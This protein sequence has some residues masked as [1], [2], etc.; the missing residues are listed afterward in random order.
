MKVSLSAMEVIALR[1]RGHR[2]KSWKLWEVIVSKLTQDVLL[3]YRIYLR[4]HFLPK[5]KITKNQKK[6]PN[7]ELK[8]KIPKPYLLQ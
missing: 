3:V 8:E 7:K 5:K 4:F 2:F 6:P 1:P